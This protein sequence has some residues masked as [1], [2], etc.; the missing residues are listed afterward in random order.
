[1]PVITISRQYASGGSDIARLVAE[2]LGWQLVDNEFVDRVAERAGITPD[3]VAEREE[4][5]PGL[6]ER[7]ARAL[8]ISSPE[9]FVAT[10][11]PPE[12]RFGSEAELVRATEAVINEAVQTEH[13]LIL[14]GRGAQAHLAQHEDTLHVYVVAPRELR[15]AAAARRLKVETGDADEAVDEIDNGRRRYVKTYYDRHWEDAGN[16]HLSLNTGIFS[17]EQ[18]ADL[19]IEAARARGWC[20]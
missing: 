9:V 7:L 8:A 5:V 15:V 4:R 3:E 6:A 18:C 2:R 10:G 11:E 17:Y 13:Q 1:M 19:I 14:V 12:P 20:S 16:Y